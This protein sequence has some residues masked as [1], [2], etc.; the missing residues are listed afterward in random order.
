[1][2]RGD[3]ADLRMQL[4]DPFLAVRGNRVT[5]SSLRQSCRFKLQFYIFSGCHLSRGLPT[6]M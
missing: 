1:M 6:K 3:F 4:P 5:T 2:L